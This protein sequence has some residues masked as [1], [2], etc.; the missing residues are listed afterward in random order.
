[1]R[2][3]LDEQYVT[4]AEAARLLHVHPSSIRRWIDAGE[5]PADRVGQRRVLIKRAALD[6][7]VRPVRPASATIEVRPDGSLVIPPMT[8]EE[9]RQA[10]AAI[11]RSRKRQAEMLAERGGVPFSPSWELLNEARDQRSRDLA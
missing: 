2:T 7:L 5:L 11:E 9:Q 8:P 4:V 3:I 10:L 6:N 1:M